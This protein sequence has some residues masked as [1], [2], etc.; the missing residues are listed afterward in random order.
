[1]SN[2]SYEF[3]CYYNQPPFDQQ[4]L[5][6]KRGRG[7]D[8]FFGDQVNNMRE[9]NFPAEQNA[10]VPSSIGA[11]NSFYPLEPEPHIFPH[12]S[13]MQGWARLNV[14]APVE[15]SR[16]SSILHDGNEFSHDLAPFSN[17]VENIAA[18]SLA[19]LDNL[20]SV[21]ST[22]EGSTD[23]RAEGTENLSRHA[24]LD[25]LDDADETMECAENR[26]REYASHGVDLGWDASHRELIL[27]YDI[28]LSR[29]HESIEIIRQVCGTRATK[30]DTICVKLQEAIEKLNRYGTQNQNAE[31][32]ARGIGLSLDHGSCL[33]EFTAASFCSG[34][35]WLASLEEAILPFLTV[36]LKIDD[37]VGVCNERPN[38]DLG[39]CLPRLLQLQKISRSLWKSSENALEYLSHYSG[40]GAVK[41]S[42]NLTRSSQLQDIEDE[43]IKIAKRKW[44]QVT[45]DTALSLADNNLDCDDL[46][47]HILWAAYRNLTGVFQ[48]RI[49]EIMHELSD[50]ATA[51]IDGKS[52]AV[53][54]RDLLYEE[55]AL[56]LR[57]EGL[58][59]D[60]GFQNRRL[61]H[62]Q[63]CMKVSLLMGSENSFDGVDTKAVGCDSLRGQGVVSGEILLL[64]LAQEFSNYAPPALLRALL[65]SAL[66]AVELECHRQQEDC[67]DE[68]F[69]HAEM[70]NTKGG[71]PCQDI[72]EAM[73]EDHRIFL[74]AEIKSIEQRRALCAE[75]CRFLLYFAEQLS[76]QLFESGPGL[77]SSQPE[78]ESTKSKCHLLHSK[79]STLLAQLSKSE[80]KLSSPLTAERSSTKSL[81]LFHDLSSSIASESLQ[82]ETVVLRRCIEC[83]HRIASCLER[84]EHILPDSTILSEVDVQGANGMYALNPCIVRIVASGIVML[85]QPS[86]PCNASKFLHRAKGESRSSR[87][88]VQTLRN[89]SCPI[90]VLR[91]GGL[92]LTGLLSQAMD[93]VLS[94]RYISATVFYNLNNESS[95]KAEGKV[96]GR[97]DSSHSGSGRHY[98][99]EMCTSAAF[100]IAAAHSRV[101]HPWV[102]RI[103]VADLRSIAGES[104]EGGRSGYGLMLP[105][106]G[107]G[108]LD[109]QMLVVGVPDRREHSGGSSLEDWARRFR[110]AVYEPIGAFMPDIM[111]VFF[112]AFSSQPCGGNCCAGSQG[113][114]LLG[115]ICSALSELA[116]SICTGRI[117]FVRAGLEGASGTVRP[118]LQGL[119][120][121]IAAATGL[122][123]GV[124]PLLLAPPGTNVIGPMWSA[125]LAGGGAEDSQHRNSRTTLN[126]RSSP[127]H[128]EATI[129]ADKKGKGRM[130]PRGGAQDYTG[131]AGEGVQVGASEPGDGVSQRKP[132]I[133]GAP[134]LKPREAVL[135]VLSG[136]P[137]GMEVSE[138][139]EAVQLLPCNIDVKEG[140]NL[141]SSITHML[142]VC[143]AAAPLR[144][145]GHAVPSAVNERPR[146]FEKVWPGPPGSGT[147]RFRISQARLEGRD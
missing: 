78:S 31:R 75:T 64:K 79:T 140:V 14:A 134:T 135:R 93:W 35:K 6:R 133:F 9:S 70:L 50:Q 12:S 100:H 76:L 57:L 137:D 89:T 59:R 62:F 63:R 34:L 77:F 27:S 51:M 22:I 58:E 2:F 73:L 74:E 28:S 65:E 71:G 124:P 86:G 110:S 29:C 39:N 24:E 43:K 67:K 80:A 111:L 69:L 141:R 136:R 98:A 99:V 91:E 56:K 107:A 48:P 102:R 41:A 10:F 11:H 25:L 115:W 5:P 42:E 47:D 145:S 30:F 142:S 18:R 119:R 131:A 66:R 117:V 96:K 60:I 97:P 72:P 132:H 125:G 68:S 146:L 82:P 87:M 53:H 144:S 37:R 7:G 138:L 103:A 90:R 49:A 85:R 17:R 118:T 13:E 106:T 105:S 113:P 38:R 121:V 147:V 26:D 55:K 4:F 61:E 92:Q 143:S 120:Q 129:T 94:G 54:Y 112:D 45:S 122:K 19:P 127:D 84:S 123:E 81:V 44:Q 52:A 32:D 33:T 36:A 40:N 88:P 126:G 15:N 101:R 128:A 23:S 108:V 139:V 95:A 1:M 109:Q 104:A 3:G 116:K 114:L 20:H 21:N 130:A 16:A 46:H 83:A 8:G